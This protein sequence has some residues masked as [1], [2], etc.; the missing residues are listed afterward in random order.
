MRGGNCRGKMKTS[1]HP[2]RRRLQ[3]QAGLNKEKEPISEDAPPTPRHSVGFLLRSKVPDLI[4]YKLQNIW[5]LSLDYGDAGY[6]YSSRAWAAFRP[7]S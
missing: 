2:D 6:D 5:Q 4:I 1:T 3:R 7:V